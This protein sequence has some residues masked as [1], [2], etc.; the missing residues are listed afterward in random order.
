VDILPDPQEAFSTAK[1]F[2][3]TVNQGQAT[4]KFEEA[5]TQETQEF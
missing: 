1:E 5:A 4:V 3:A 2:Y